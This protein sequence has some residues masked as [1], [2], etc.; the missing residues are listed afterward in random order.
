MEGKQW[1]SRHVCMVIRSSHQVVCSSIVGASI[2]KQRQ[3]A[4]GAAAC[5]LSWEQ[6]E[7]RLAL[8]PQAVIR[9]FV[10]ACRPNISTLATRRTSVTCRGAAVQQ[11]WNKHRL[12]MQRLQQDALLVAAAACSQLQQCEEGSASDASHHYGNLSQP[13]SHRAILCGRASAHPPVWV[14]K[15]ARLWA[16]AAAAAAESRSAGNGASNL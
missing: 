8:M 12:A 15:L 6:L 2:C 5:V 13:P 10:S 14:P 16:A 4:M 3:L 9:L 7:E 11:E 1:A